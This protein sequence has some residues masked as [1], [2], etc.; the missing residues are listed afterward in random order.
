MFPKLIEVITSNK[1][2]GYSSHSPAPKEKTF[3][4]LKRLRNYPD[5]GVTI[6]Q[7]WKERGKK[8]SLDPPEA[9]NEGWQKD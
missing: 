7:W 2:Y 5:T 8:Y 9:V 1:G 6:S 3:T 4:L